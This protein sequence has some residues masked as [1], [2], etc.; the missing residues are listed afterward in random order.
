M[1]KTRR[2][3]GGGRR[4]TTAAAGTY[5]YSDKGGADKDG[6]NKVEDRDNNDEGEEDEGTTKARTMRPTPGAGMTRMDT[7]RTGQT[8]PRIGTMRTTR[9]SRPLGWAVMAHT[10]NANKIK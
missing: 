2:R 9:T 7:T 8:R 1:A 10:R 6:A 4:D 3:K 5:K